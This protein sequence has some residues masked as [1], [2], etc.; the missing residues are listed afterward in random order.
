MAN[1]VSK[2][3]G[4]EHDEAVRLTGELN[5]KVTKLSEE[6]DAMQGGDFSGG[7]AVESL[8][9]GAWVARKPFITFTADDGYP[10]DITILEP[11][12]KHYDVPCCIA[13]I[14]TSINNLEERLDLQ[15]NHRWE[16]ICHS[17]SST[18]FTS[19]SIEEV[20]SAM[21]ES[22]A[23]LEDMG[24]II[25]DVAYPSGGC[26]AAIKQVAKKYFRAGYE[27]NPH[28]SLH[29]N[30][31]ILDSFSI[32]RAPLGSFTQSDAYAT[33][34][35][36]KSLVD[37][38]IAENGW[39][40]FCLHSGA[41]AFDATQQQHLDDVIAYAQ[42]LGVEIGNLSEG[43]EIFGNYLECGASYNVSVPKSDDDMKRIVIAN[44]GENNLP[45][46]KLLPLTHK[47][48]ESITAYPMDKISIAEISHY[49][50]GFPMNCGGTL[51][52]SRFENF[53]FQLWF[54]Y[55][56]HAVYRRAWVSGAWRSFERITADPASDTTSSKKFVFADG[57][58]DSFQAV[59]SSHLYIKTF[60]IIT[61]G[62][63]ATLTKKYFALSD[64][65]TDKENPTTIGTTSDGMDIQMVYQSNGAN[66]YVQFRYS[67]QTSF[68][69]AYIEIAYK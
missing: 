30:N 37:R 10:Q 51:V 2:Y 59:L 4:A 45:I 6:I 53:G 7:T 43:Y 3:S 61:G 32:L 26:N 19:M 16:F 41:A 9:N 28:N 44:S 63:T 69:S 13:M 62:V 65:S 24:F 14:S 47:A 12:F 55:Y 15:K 31:G 34:E 23:A 25:K 60:D 21:V 67:G 48:S 33:L 52:T 36:Y 38:A 39:L 17:N 54:P 42:S 64:I 11:I 20:E 57:W 49:G 27:F 56:D 29:M 35:Y 58:S 8:K 50:T 1:F 5:G 22:K 66:G 40:I 18:P 68:N 46:M